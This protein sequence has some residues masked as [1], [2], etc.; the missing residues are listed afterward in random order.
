MEGG[1]MARLSFFSFL[2][3]EPLTLDPVFFIASSPFMI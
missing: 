3:P 1:R 2:N